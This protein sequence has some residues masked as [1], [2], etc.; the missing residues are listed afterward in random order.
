MARTDPG[1]SEAAADGGLSAAI[2]RRQLLLGAA[3]AAAASILR[4]GPAEAAAPDKLVRRAQ[5]RAGGKKVLERVRLLAWDGEAIVH[6][7]A[8]DIAI[9]VSTIIVPFVE[10]RSSTW[11][12]AQGKAATRTMIVKADGAT[13]EWKGILTPLPPLVAAHERAQFAI[14]G[15][16]LLQFDSGRAGLRRVAGLHGLS[17]LRVD[18]PYAPKTRLYFESDGRLAEATNVVPGPE[19]GRPIHQHFIF[20]EEQMPGPVRWPRSFRLEQ[21]GRPYLEMKLSRFEAAI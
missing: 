16:M 10:A 9:G 4:P 18:H 1:D 11:P 7:G 19:D 2:G 5:A 17:G 21:E 13:A 6:D 8:R 14:Y 20:S 12:L 3:A 15:L